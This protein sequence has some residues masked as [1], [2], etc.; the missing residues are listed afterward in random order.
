[1]FVVGK[2]FVVDLEDE[3]V[4]SRGLRV[5]LAVG[6]NDGGTVFK[7]FKPTDEVTVS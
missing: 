6:F 5:V 3:T 4:L 7:P 1:M 2:K